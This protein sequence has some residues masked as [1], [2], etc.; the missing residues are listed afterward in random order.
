MC[1]EMNAEMGDIKRGKRRQ[2]Y[3]HYFRHSCDRRKR[4]DKS[5]GEIRTASGIL[6]RNLFERD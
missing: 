6:M 3:G 2:L 5:D 4:M 1:R